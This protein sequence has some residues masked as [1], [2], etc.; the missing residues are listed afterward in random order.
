MI[1]LRLVI[2]FFFFSPLWELNAAF[3]KGK[4]KMKKE[5]KRE[6]FWVLHFKNITLSAKTEIKHVNRF[7]DS[8][9]PHSSPSE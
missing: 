1:V 7:L 8:R 4:M 2:F 3:L 5:D 9:F 6:I